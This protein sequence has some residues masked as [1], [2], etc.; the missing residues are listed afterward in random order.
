M[1]ISRAGK[2]GER[3]KKPWIKRLA[4]VTVVLAVGTAPGISLLHAVDEKQEMT[5]NTGGGYL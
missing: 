2:D 4:A 1:R 3:M 5:G